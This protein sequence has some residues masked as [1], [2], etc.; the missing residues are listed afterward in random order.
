[1]TSSL[2]HCHYG[3]ILHRCSRL[4]EKIPS[5]C[6]RCVCAKLSTWTNITPLFSHNYLF[7]NVPYGKRY[8]FCSQQWILSLQQKKYP[9]PSWPK[10]VPSSK[11]LTG[12]LTAKA[13]QRSTPKPRVGCPAST[14]THGS[15]ERKRYLP[16]FTFPARPIQVPESCTACFDGGNC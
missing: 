5:N 2:L 12:F 11:F 14:P 9:C 13:L 8:L 7:L 16:A 10:P 3:G 6:S 15:V 4:P 1:M